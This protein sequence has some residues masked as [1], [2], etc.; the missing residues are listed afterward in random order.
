MKDD[1]PKIYAVG[2]N[3]KFCFIFIFIF[4]KMAYPFINCIY[5]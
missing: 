1:N 4:E 5:L 3:S 2:I